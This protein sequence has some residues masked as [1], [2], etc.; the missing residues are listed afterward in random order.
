MTLAPAARG[1]GGGSPYTSLS[2][3]IPGL[4]LNATK[5]AGRVTARHTH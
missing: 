5:G 4:Y 1:L 2:D 3:S